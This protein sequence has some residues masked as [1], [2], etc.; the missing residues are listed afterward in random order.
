MNSDNIVFLNQT[1]EARAL[2]SLNRLTGLTWE[3]TPYS[4]VNRGP[5]SS[6]TK[7]A[8]PKSPADSREYRPEKKIRTGNR[9]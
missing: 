8:F 3:R 2:E 9:G 1:S 4:L 7:T 5:I 6:L